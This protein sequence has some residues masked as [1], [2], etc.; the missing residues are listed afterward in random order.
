MLYQRG[1]QNR[2]IGQQLLCT[3]VIYCKSIF[4]IKV[5]KCI[6]YLHINDK[7]EHHNIK[8]RGTGMCHV[9]IVIMY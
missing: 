8:L 9:C 5:L 6:Q 2:T 3:I 7:L 1:K 4:N